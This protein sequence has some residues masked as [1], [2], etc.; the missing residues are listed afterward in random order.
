MGSIAHSIV[1]VKCPTTEKAAEVAEAMK[2]NCNPRKWVCVEA[3]IVKSDVNGNIAMLLMTT[4]QGGMADTISS[5]FASL[6]AEKIDSIEV[7]PTMDEE[8][9]EVF[10]DEFLVDEEF[11]DGE[12][13]SEEDD[14]VVF[15]P[16][17]DAGDAPADMAEEDFID[18][19]PAV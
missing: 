16:D 19:M 17:F 8:Y 13:Y 14:V 15:L 18:V 1:L 5:N 2:A 4:Q 6:N 7:Y 11:F 3:D 10:E 9:E 12:V